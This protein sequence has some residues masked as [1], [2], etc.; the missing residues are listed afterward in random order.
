MKDAGERTRDGA[1]AG[2]KLSDQQ[3]A[4]ASFC[5]HALGAAYAGIR[6]EGDLTEQLENFYAF[7][8]AEG[9]PDGGRRH[10]S[11]HDADQRGEETQTAGSCK[12]ARSQEQWHG[13]DRQPD[14]FGEHPTEQDR[15]S[16]MEKKF[17]SAVHGW[18][19]WSPIISKGKEQYAPTRPPSQIQR[20]ICV[21]L[22]P[23]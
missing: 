12:R 20:R 17:D 16:M 13:R 4:G 15:V 11:E 8:A 18:R 7:E 1:Q 22:W 19:L 6:F 21:F 2:K 14:L 3:R 5:E 10:R 23:P 9:I